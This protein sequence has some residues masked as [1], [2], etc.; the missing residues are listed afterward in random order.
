MVEAFFWF[1][2]WYL[3]SPRLKVVA[4]SNGWLIY[5]FVPNW[6][7]STAT[8]W[9]LMKLVQM[10]QTSMLPRGQ[11]L[12]WERVFTF[13]TCEIPQHLFSSQLRIKRTVRLAIITSAEEDMLLMVPGFV[14]LLVGWFVCR[15]KQKLVNRFQQNLDRGPP[16]PFG[17][18]LLKGQ[19]VELNS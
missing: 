1:W 6:N 17:A 4:R 12:T 18:G 13:E 19:T 8:G 16:L 14:C 2:H 11:I 9:I 5:S 10:V 7:I 3:N 15:I